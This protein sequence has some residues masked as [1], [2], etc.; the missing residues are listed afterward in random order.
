MFS[1]SHVMHE[2]SVEIPG[3]ALRKVN[4]SLPATSRKFPFFIFL[5]LLLATNNN[6]RQNEQTTNNLFTIKIQTNR[7]D[8]RLKVTDSTRL[9]TTNKKLNFRYTDMYGNHGSVNHVFRRWKQQFHVSCSP[10]PS[11]KRQITKVPCTTLTPISDTTTPPPLKHSTTAGVLFRT[12]LFI[13]NSDGL[14]QQRWLIGKEPCISCFSSAWFLWQELR[15]KSLLRGK[16]PGRKCSKRRY[17][18]FTL[19]HPFNPSVSIWQS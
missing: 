19:I 16:L 13:L 7:R 2:R 5:N 1:K 3:H 12:S 6:N 15:W 14:C 4:P 10:L 9:F 17:V 8:A 18:M 11:R